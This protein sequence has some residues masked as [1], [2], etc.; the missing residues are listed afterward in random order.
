MEGFYFIIFLKSNMSASKEINDIH[1]W[2]R[3]LESP[4]PI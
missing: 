4:L 2:I 1:T 3:L